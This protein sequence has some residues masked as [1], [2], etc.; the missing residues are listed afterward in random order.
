ML[1]LLI[2]SIM[3]SEILDDDTVNTE[4]I[5]PLAETT[6]VLERRPG[7]VVAIPEAT[8]KFIFDRFLSRRSG[9]TM[10]AYRSDLRAFAD[11]LGI[12]STDAV[13]LL[14]GLKKRSDATKLV[15]GWVQAM[16]QDQKLA[17]ATRARRI[18]TLRALTQLMSE[19]GAIEW[20]LKI[21]MPKVERLRDTAGPPEAEIHR[22]FAACGDDAEGQRDRLLLALLGPPMGLRRREVAQLTFGDFDERRRKLRVL[23]KGKEHPSLKPV[24]SEVAD[25]IA[26]WRETREAQGVITSSSPLLCSVGGKHPGEKLSLRGVGYVV[27]SIGERAGITVWPHALRHATGTVSL[28]RGHGIAETQGLLGHENPK[29]TMRYDDNRQN[30]GA[31][32]SSDLSR[33]FLGKTIRGG[34]SIEQPLAMEELLKI[35]DDFVLAADLPMDPPDGC[36]ALKH[37]QLASI[38]G[39]GERGAERCW[40]N[41]VQLD[42][43]ID[44]GRVRVERFELP[45]LP[46]DESGRVDEFLNRFSGHTRGHKQLCARSAIWLLR[47]GRKFGADVEYIA[48]RC[49]VHALG[50]PRIYVECGYTSAEKVLT[51]LDRTASE[52]AVVPYDVGDSLFLFKRMISLDQHLFEQAPSKLAIGQYCSEYIRNA[53]LLG[54]DNVTAGIGL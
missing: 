34:S 7:V 3:G 25:L 37:P 27:A 54:D 48:G 53:Q 13:A 45:S 29:T 52:V 32:A 18:S 36:A 20:D 40:E 19:L 8:P 17:P 50:D 4:V 30:R 51:V 5:G 38:F 12:D 35:A 6:I 15:M 41:L 28:D 47:Q 9:N 39:F 10:E 23:R 11:H 31:K 44:V 22:L 33:L 24:P 21:K 16:E 43:L 1:P 42:A 46:E 14:M 49:D 26:R 2:E